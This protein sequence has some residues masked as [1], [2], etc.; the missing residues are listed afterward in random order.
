[1]KGGAVGNALGRVC[2]R[3]LRAVVASKK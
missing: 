1:V 2:Y 3:L